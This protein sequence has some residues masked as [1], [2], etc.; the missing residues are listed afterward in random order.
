MTTAPPA[1]GIR[2]PLPFGLMWL[3]RWEQPMKQPRD[4]EGECGNC[5]GWSWMWNF[6]FSCFFWFWSL[7]AVRLDIKGLTNMDLESIMFSSFILVVCAEREKVGG[8][9]RSPQ[10]TRR[11]SSAE[12]Q[13]GIEAMFYVPVL[14]LYFHPKKK[15]MLVRC[16]LRSR[17]GLSGITCLCVYVRFVWQVRDGHISR[18][19]Q[20]KH[21]CMLQIKILVWRLCILWTEGMFATCSLPCCMMLDRGRT[22]PE[23]PGMILKMAKQRRHNRTRHH[24]RQ[25]GHQ[26]WLGWD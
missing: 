13:F 16:L 1:R 24:Q 5:M 6:Y 25:L 3:G 12:L 17:L 4:L 19:F 2:H 20:L 26:L 15:F 8:K 11:C 14:M 7:H 10:A 23:T 21:R 22:L 18:Q 9:G